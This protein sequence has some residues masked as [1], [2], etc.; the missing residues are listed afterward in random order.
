MA[1]AGRPIVGSRL[2]VAWTGRDDRSF[3][4]TSSEP[5]HE[6]DGRGCGPVPALLPDRSVRNAKLQWGSPAA[7]T[8]RP[9]WLIEHHN[10]GG[11]NAG[12]VSPASQSVPFG[13]AAWSAQ[14]ACWAENAKMRPA[15]RVAANRGPRPRDIRVPAWSEDCSLRISPGDIIEPLGRGNTPAPDSL[16]EGCHAKDFAPRGDRDGGGGRSLGPTATGRPSA[17][18]QSGSV[19]RGRTGRWHHRNCSPW[20]G[21]ANRVQARSRGTRCGSPR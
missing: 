21:A 15:Q 19:P 16:L 2:W 1:D 11:K 3:A 7:G 8:L 4:G 6:A 20:C 12:W 10:R 14:I 13:I 17:A 5:L 18:Q 9:A